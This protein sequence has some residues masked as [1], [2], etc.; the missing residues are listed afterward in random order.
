MSLITCR[1]TYTDIPWA[2]RQHKHDGH[3][4]LIHGHNWGISITFGCREPDENGFVVDFGKLKY[5][6]AW[7]EHNLDHAC[8][9]SS[10]DPYLEE[11]SAVGGSKVWKMYVVPNCSSE[12]MAQ[13]LYSVFDP[14]VRKATSNRAFVVAIEVTED[15]KNSATF[16]DTAVAQE[17]ATWVR[18]MVSESS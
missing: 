10:D 7:I 17:S 13:Y 1:K 8:V 9:L 6:K 11:L 4:S 12:G 5:L 2:H 16:T 15:S 14:I 18:D 3:C